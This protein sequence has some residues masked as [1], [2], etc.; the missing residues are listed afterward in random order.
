[1]YVNIGAHMCTNMQGYNLRA[2]TSY[3]TADFQAKGGWS[4]QTDPLGSESPTVVSAMALVQ[5]PH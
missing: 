1:M 4:G 3:C 2:H 5:R